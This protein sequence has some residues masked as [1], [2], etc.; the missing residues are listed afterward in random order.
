MVARL[1]KFYNEEV[2]PRM[3]KENNYKNKFQ[4]PRL[5]KIVVN[6]GIGDANENSAY[7]EA[8]M[9]ELSKITGQKPIVTRAKKAVSNFKIKKGDPVGCKVTLRRDRMYDFLDRFI[10]V[11]LPRIRDFKGLKRTSFDGH[12]NYTCG[13]DDEA[14]FPELEY[15]EIKRTQGMDVVFTIES[16][17]DKESCDLL[18]RFGMPFKK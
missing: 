18:R 5:K 1:R 2:I 3:M 8:A 4:V 11:A 13:I 15:D 12:G 9:E 14:V 16:K 7:L 10:N 6:M 17:S